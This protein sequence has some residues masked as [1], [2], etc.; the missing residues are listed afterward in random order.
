[1]VHFEDV[2][3]VAIPKKY[4]CI[5]KQFVSRMIKMNA[6]SI[7]DEYERKIKKTIF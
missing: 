3:V 1:M 6:F 5:T 2:G 4:I 7:S